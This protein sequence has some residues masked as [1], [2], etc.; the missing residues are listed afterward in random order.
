MPAANHP[1]YKQEL[2]RCRYTLDYV[3]KSI[4]R[5]LEKR[6]KIGNELEHVKKHMSGDNS[7]DY[8]SVMVNTMLHDTLALKI[9]NLYTARDKPYFAKIDFRET[10]TISTEN[11][12]IGKMSLAKYEDQEI[13]IVDWRAPI[14]NL[15]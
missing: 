7:A 9:K 8:T 6:V 11:L 3:E 14:A 12:Y 2:E 1:A 5:A 15:Y 13:V 10:G 4:E